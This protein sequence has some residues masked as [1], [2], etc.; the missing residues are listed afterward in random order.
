M[1]TTINSNSVILPTSTQYSIEG[2]VKIGITSSSTN[3]FTQP[4]N[5]YGYVPGTEIS[6]GVPGKA[7]NWYRVRWQTVLD[8]NGGGAQGSGAA[9]Y[10]YTPSSGW[11]NVQ[12]QGMHACMEN[13]ISDIYMQ[14]RCDYLCPVHPTYPTEAHSFRI[15][16]MSWNIAPRINCSIDKDLRRNGWQ[17]NILEIYEM[18]TAVIHSGN[19][20]RY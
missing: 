19:L 5:V 20:T 13:D 15:Y 4:I 16:T 9:L 10:R 2:I 12:A 7:N 18:D 8:D 1:A 3:D 11:V 17:N 6:M 14:Q